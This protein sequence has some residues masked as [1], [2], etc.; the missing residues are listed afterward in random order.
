ML[1]VDELKQA[2]PP[3]LR[4]AATQGLADMVNSITTDPEAAQN[5]RENFVGY[6]HVLKEGRFKTEDYVSGVAYVTFKLMGYTNQESYKRTFPARYQALVARGATDKDIS[7]YVSAYNKNKLVNMILEQTL[8][9]VWVLNQ[10]LYQKA[11]NVQAKLMID[12]LVSPKVRSDAANS[13]LTHLKKPETK[14]VELSLGMV[15]NTGMTE[16]N[17]MLMALAG[18]QQELIAQ[19]ATTREIAHQTLGATHTTPHQTIAHPN[20]KTVMK[21]P[22]AII[23]A[24]AVHVG[25]PVQSKGV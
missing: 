9:P 20:G 23:E 8:V 6:T 5:I 17:A 22:G 10:D 14:Q 24:T 4:T 2:L 7:A 25:S 16:L 15:E 13:L 3:A 11:I 19:G 21:Q 12:P 18:R 1:T